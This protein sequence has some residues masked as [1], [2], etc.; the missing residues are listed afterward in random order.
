LPKPPPEAFG[1][2]KEAYDALPEKLRRSLRRN[3]LRE[4]DAQAIAELEQE[5]RGMRR[6]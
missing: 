3:A 6:V 4:A 1:L 2:P 5:L